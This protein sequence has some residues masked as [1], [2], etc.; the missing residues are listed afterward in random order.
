VLDYDNE[1]QSAE[2]DIPQT[3]DLIPFLG[4]KYCHSSYNNEKTKSSEPYFYQDSNGK[5][6]N[7]DDI[8]IL[9][10]LSLSDL[11]LK[12]RGPFITFEGYSDTGEDTI[13]NYY[14]VKGYAEKPFPPL[15]DYTQSE[16][17]ED[18]IIQEENE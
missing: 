15:F 16:E 3:P 4:S 9:N 12:E 8:D 14:C 13:H 18:E 17:E 2:I 1:I 11:Y 5:M 10:S 7:T 6:N